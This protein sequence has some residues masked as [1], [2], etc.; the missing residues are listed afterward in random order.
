MNET[1]RACIRRLSSLHAP[2][3]RWTPLAAS[4]LF[5]AAGW[6]GPGILREIAFLGA[7]ALV[8]LIGADIVQS[9][10][11]RDSFPEHAHPGPK[12][13]FPM[14]LLRGMLTLALGDMYSFL[15]FIGVG[16]WTPFSLW[17]VLFL[18]C[19]FIAWRNVA[20]WY[21]EGVE[22]EGELAEVEQQHS[23]AA[24]PGRAAPTP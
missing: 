9:F 7:S 15:L 20:L 5:A 11:D 14:L 23:S 12:L 22:F 21:E 2:L 3:G 4:C 6:A 16:P 10:I 18:L 1:F 8:V 17:P 13:T 19:G 24:H